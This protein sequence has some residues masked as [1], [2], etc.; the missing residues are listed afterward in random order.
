MP[1]ADGFA[2]E[3]VTD[4]DSGQCEEGRCAATRD[5]SYPDGPYGTSVGETIMDLTLGTADGGETSFG[6]IRVEDGARLLLIFSTAAW[7]GR[8]AGDMP[9]LIQLH[10]RHQANGLRMRV[11]LFES[12]DHGE[13]SQR[14]AD[15]YGRGNGLPF[16]VLVDKTGQLHPFFPRIALPMVMIV[17]LESMALVHADIGWSLESFESLVSDRLS[18][19][20]NTP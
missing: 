11:S 16:P 3:S 13:P 8:C 20:A 12:A 1:C 7:C 6:E 2:C 5:L 10:E 4:C 18:G 17:D 14:D 9:E 19:G 15:L